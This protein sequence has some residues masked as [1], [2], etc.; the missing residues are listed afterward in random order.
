MK[1]HTLIKL[2]EYRMKRDQYILV[3]ESAFAKVFKTG[4]QK[5]D[6]ALVHTI[7]NPE[8]RKQRSELDSDRPG[9]QRNSVGGTHGLGG[10]VDSQDHDIENFARDLCHLLQKD[11]LEGKFASLQIAAAPHMLGMLR[12]FLSDDCQKALDKTV[13]KNL[14]HADEKDILAHFA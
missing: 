11:H 2:R 3:A 5:Q 12:K 10:D 7:E 6:F 8:G 9:V 1:L 13:N 4:P 14:I